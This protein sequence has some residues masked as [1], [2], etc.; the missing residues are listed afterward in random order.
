MQTAPSSTVTTSRAE[1]R[2]DLV[3]HGADRAHGRA[4]DE[5]VHGVQPHRAAGG[6]RRGH[7]RRAGRFDA[8]EPH[9]AA[10]ARLGSSRRPRSARRRRPGRPSRPAARPSCCSTSR[11]TVP[12]PATVRGIVE[13]RAPGSTRWRRRRVGRPCAASSKVSPVSTSS[14]RPPPCDEDAVPLLPRGGVRQVD[15][16]RD[17]EQPAGERDALRVVAGAGADHARAPASSGASWAIRLNAPRTLY[18]RTTC[19]SSRL[20]S[21]SQPS[22]RGQPGAALQRGQRGD[23]G[24]PDRRRV[25]VAAVTER[26]R[27][28]RCDA[29]GR[30][31]RSILSPSV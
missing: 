17:V 24:E 27:P 31:H 28:R 8:D 3:G 21:T 22:L 11:A 30:G 13:R 1:R 14:T 23:A 19:R 16:A 25:D 18:D 20:S 7:G 5:R 9:A 26:D 4:V 29:I 2:D 6:Q 15:P 12:C 10:R